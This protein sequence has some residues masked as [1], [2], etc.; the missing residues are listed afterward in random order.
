MAITLRQLRIFEAT[1]RLGRLT[2][3]ADEQALSQSA[4]SQALK[5]LESSLDYRLFNRRG[6][7]LLMTDSGQDV[8]P[9]IRE[10]LDL[11]DSLK[12]PDRNALCGHL[13]VV[14]SVT[15]GCYLLPNLMAEF[16]KCY[17]GV[18]PD[19]QIANTRQVIERLE[20]GQA[21]IG[22]IEGP[23]LHKQLQITPWREDSLEVF[24]HPDHTLAG[25][26]VLTREQIPD[27]RWILREQGSGTRAIFNQALQR[28]GVQASV[29]LALNRQEAIKQSVKAGL[30][31]GCLSRL[32]VAEEVRAGELV[33]L[34][35]PLELSRQLSLVTWPVD[36]GSTLTMTFVDFLER[37]RI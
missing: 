20:K 22:M 8:L 21:H 7:D 4:A 1:A 35:T 23:A 25:A 28:L 3:A 37:T 10:I 19:L 27:Q 6:R 12:N 9:R 2:Q 18:E 16:I 31:I 13:R 30:G 36:Q 14:A 32:S 11:V 26:G 17:P 34:E 29:A 24:C 5:E 15:I 33:V